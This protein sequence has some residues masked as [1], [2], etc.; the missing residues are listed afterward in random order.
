M[1]RDAGDAEWEDVVRQRVGMMCGTG[2]WPS[3]GRYLQKIEEKEALVTLHG[4]RAAVDRPM[5]PRVSSRAPLAA[6]RRG[7]ASAALRWRTCQVAARNSWATFAGSV[8]SLFYVFRH[9][10]MHFADLVSVPI[11]SSLE[12]SCH[13]GG[14]LH[15]RSTLSYKIRQEVKGQ[16]NNA[17]RH[18]KLNF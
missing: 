7:S 12:T 10:F 18:F 4:A 17:S 15:R 6:P 11:M 1:A 13:V 3:V 9:R 16:G 8:S 14:I 5:R 2:C